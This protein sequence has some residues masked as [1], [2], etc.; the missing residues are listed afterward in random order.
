MNIQDSR[1]LSK[2]STVTT[3]VPTVSPSD[4]HTD[5]S[6]DSLDIYKGEFFINLADDL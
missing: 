6:W 4:D 2:R 5:G 1:I 3:Q